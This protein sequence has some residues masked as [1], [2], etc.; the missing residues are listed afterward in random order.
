V[1]RIQIRTQPEQKRLVIPLAALM[2]DQE[3][4]GVVVVD[5]VKMVDN[6]DG[7]TEKRGKAH[8]RRAIL[9]V[10]DR[11]RQLVE[12]LTLEDREKKE[13]FAVKD[14]WF[15]VEGG[16]GLHDEDIVKL[17]VGPGAG[18]RSQESG[19]RSQRFDP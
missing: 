19:V 15:V 11:G 14:A 5:E 8:K 1:Q 13:C 18:V 10:R 2:E 3:P 4:P 16:H 7:T 6:P 9:G 12:V 17:E